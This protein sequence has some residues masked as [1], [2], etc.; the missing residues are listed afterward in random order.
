[1]PDRIRLGISACLLGEK[2]RYDGQ[3]KLDRSLRDTLGRFVEY[4]PVCPEVEVGLPVPRPA[5]HLEGDP[6]NPRLVFTKS[7]EEI[8]GR[9]KAWAAR[10]L[11]E[12]E[13]KGLCGFIFKAGSP[14]SGMERVCVT[15][16]RG[17]PE[18]KGVGIWARAFMDRFPLLP[19]EDEGRLHDPDLRENFIERVFTLRR[20]RDAMVAG[21]TRGNLVA[22]HT[23]HK[24][25]LQ[26]HGE[27]GARQMSRLVAHAKELGSADLYNRY[28]ALLMDTL[29]KRATVKRHTNV[30]QHM[31]GYFKRELS[32]EEKQELLEVIER[33]RA[34]L[35]PLIVP[36]TLLNHYVRKYDQA[37]LREQVYLNPHPVELRLR[38]HC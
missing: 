36:V 38:N 21:K 1:M 11:R 37:Y 22:F 13:G 29:R 35:V 14:S 7:G 32:A 25:L 31:M 3:H 12:L 15:N 30:L 4:V 18:K 8:T 16:A 9:V 2:V 10:R 28:L 24:Y 34:G 26:A 5:L 33:Y 6:E 17:M 20:W 23:R 27:Q 19:V